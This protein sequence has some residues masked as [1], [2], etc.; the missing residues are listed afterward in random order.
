MEVIIV[1]RKILCKL[2]FLLNKYQW[3][4]E[5]IGGEWFYVIPR[6][7]PWMEFWTT[8]PLIHE[9]VCRHEKYIKR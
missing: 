2:W 7:Y 1:M 5:Y 6:P 3:Y 9:H 8:N 4:R